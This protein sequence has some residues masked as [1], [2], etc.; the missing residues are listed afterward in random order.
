MAEPKMP[1]DID[2]GPPDPYADDPAY[3]EYLSRGPECPMC[4]GENTHMNEPIPSMMGYGSDESLHCDDCDQDFAM[5]PF[6]GEFGG[7]KGSHLAGA[8]EEIDQAV[9]PECGGSYDNHEPGCSLD[10]NAEGPDAND[11]RHDMRKENPREGVGFDKYMDKILVQEGH[12]RKVTKQE[13]S[14]QRR[15]QAVRQ[16]RPMGRVR[17]GGK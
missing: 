10:V 12:N 15:R 11:A 17:F 3:Q 8:E 7:G 5:N 9:C 6:T 14:P 2:D 16:E 4:G 1:L 13:D